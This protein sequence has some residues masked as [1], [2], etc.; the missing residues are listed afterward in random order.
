MT[1]DTDSPTQHFRQPFV[2]GILLEKENLLETKTKHTRQKDYQDV[3]QMD[4]T[5]SSCVVIS[6]SSET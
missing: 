2:S 6:L 3:D 4:K 5:D 1:A